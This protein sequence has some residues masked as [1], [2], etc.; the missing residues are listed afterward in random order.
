[1]RAPTDDRWKPQQNERESTSCRAG[2]R[3]ALG[4]RPPL[5]CAFLNSGR[6][7]E[8]V[9]FIHNATSLHQDRDYQF[10]GPRS[11]SRSAAQQCGVDFTLDHPGRPLGDSACRPVA[12]V[13][14]AGPQHV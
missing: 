2:S 13:E 12:V 7:E 10:L 14:S 6:R 3:R 1:M 8:R 9:P 4:D 11:R 5:R